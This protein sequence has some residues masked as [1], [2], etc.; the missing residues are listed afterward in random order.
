MERKT[1]RNSLLQ[2]LEEGYNLDDVGD[3]LDKVK[4]EMNRKEIIQKHIKEFST[5]WQG[6]SNGRWYTYLPDDTK[7]KGRRLIAKSSEER[8]HQEIISYYKALEEAH[9]KRRETLA[10]FYPEWLR[11]KSLHTDATSYVRRIDDD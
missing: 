9:E 3:V 6:E 10:S 11:Y 8:I 4:E 7:K 2:F 5:I 1:I